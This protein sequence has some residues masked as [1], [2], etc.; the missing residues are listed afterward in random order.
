M[1]QELPTSIRLS[2]ATKAKLRSA[3]SASRRPVSAQIVYI[4]ELWI[5]MWEGQKK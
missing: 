1:P 5:K 3:A 4:L 2:R